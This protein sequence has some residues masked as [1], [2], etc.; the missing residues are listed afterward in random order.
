MSYSAKPDGWY[1]QTTKGYD[2]YGREH[3]SLDDHWPVNIF[4]Y[5]VFLYESLI[6]CAFSLAFNMIL[7]F[8]LQE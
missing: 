5:M 2:L 3:M 7:T 4:N 1:Y 8:M 6:S